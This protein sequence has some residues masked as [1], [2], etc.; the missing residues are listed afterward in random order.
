M[1]PP[2]PATLPARKAALL[3][4]VL[5]VRGANHQRPGRRPERLLQSLSYP[6]R[7]VRK[8]VVRWPPLKAS[9]N[10]T[11]SAICHSDEKFRLRS[12]LAQAI[13]RGRW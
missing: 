11:Y 13:A 12:P 5:I 3:R 4:P 7:P 10:L 6:R 8:R 1:E 9:R 2:L